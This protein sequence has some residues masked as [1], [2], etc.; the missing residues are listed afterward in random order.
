MD[1]CSITEPLL[2]RNCLDSLSIT[3]LLSLKHSL[4]NLEKKKE[5]IIG[6]STKLAKHDISNVSSKGESSVEPIALPLMADVRDYV[7]VTYDY[8]DSWQLAEKP[9]KFQTFFQ[10]TITTL[11]FLSFGGYLL[12]LIVHAIKNKGPTTYLH[13][14]APTM[15]TNSNRIKPIKIYKRNRRSIIN[16]NPYIFSNQPYRHYFT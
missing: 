12:C 9:S 6:I 1:Y 10:I 3:E 7:P 13:P 16:S 14:M 8:K 2:F 5:N 11:A 15:D 4:N